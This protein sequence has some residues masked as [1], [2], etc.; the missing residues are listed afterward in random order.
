MKVD[1]HGPRPPLHLRLCAAGVTRGLPLLPPSASRARHA[2]AADRP[3]GRELGRGERKDHP[4]PSLPPP[5]FSCCLPLPPA[6]EAPRPAGTPPR[7]H[8]HTAHDRRRGPL[9]RCGK[10][11]AGRGRA[12]ALGSQIQSLGGR[13]ADISPGP[14]SPPSA[15]L[16]GH[17]EATVSLGTRCRDCPHSLAAQTS[18]RLGSEEESKAWRV[19]GSA[20]SG[21]FCT[22]G[23]FTQTGAFNKGLKG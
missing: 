12:T 5:R 6:P 9:S 8:T 21:K 13:P 3:P 18:E 1:F 16:Y 7:P 10:Y 19:S 23:C 22:R 11:A 20:V 4:L 14:V 15:L 2:S 17:R